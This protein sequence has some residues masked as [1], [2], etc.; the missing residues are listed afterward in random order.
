[1]TQYRDIDLTLTLHPLTR[2]ITD[3]F[4][5]IAIKRSLRNLMQLEK[6]DIPFSPDKYNPISESLFELT[7]TITESVIKKKLEWLIT[8]ETRIKVNNIDVHL[9]LEGNGYDINL[10]YDIIDL[11]LSD[12]FSHKIN[13]KS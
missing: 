5:D 7:S 2:D 6:W 13:R 10:L 12:S 3:K 1:M 9:N 4:D 8:V 11:D